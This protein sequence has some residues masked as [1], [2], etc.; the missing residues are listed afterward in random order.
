MLLFSTAL[1]AELLREAAFER[2]LQLQ[3]SLPKSSEKF[4]RRPHWI[5]VPT[6][7]FGAG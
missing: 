5:S 3:T 7:T 6:I 4:S 2:E 1:A